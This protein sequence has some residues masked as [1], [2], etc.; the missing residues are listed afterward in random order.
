MRFRAA[1]KAVDENEGPLGRPFV[2]FSCGNNDF[3]VLDADARLCS[4]WIPAHSAA[5]LRKPFSL[6]ELVLRCFKRR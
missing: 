3:A 6:R 5:L 2:V 4:G 1:R